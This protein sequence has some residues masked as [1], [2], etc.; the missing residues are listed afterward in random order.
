MTHDPGG[1][2]RLPLP[3]YMRGGADFCGPDGCYRVMLWRAW[4]D[5]DAPYPLLIGMNPSTA[6]ADVNDPTVHKEIGFTQRWGFS[7]Y[8][9]GNVSAYRATDPKRLRK[10]PIH[11][12]E[13]LP[14]I[15]AAAKGAAQ[16]VVAFGNV[17]HEMRTLAEEV[18]AALRA[19]NISLWCF[20]M[21][22]DGSPCHPLYLPSNTRLV[23]WPGWKRC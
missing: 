7:R 19:A 15:M 14:A 6:A 4:G 23:E 20:G 12:D 17:K 8:Y 3:L 5:P 1:K 2:V 18:V 11:C 21:N 22:G 13:N 16:V 9:K 10:A